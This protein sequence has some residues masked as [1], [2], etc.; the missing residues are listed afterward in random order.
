MSPKHMSNPSSP[1]NTVD[2]ITWQKINGLN[3]TLRVTSSN[4]VSQPQLFLPV[5]QRV[6]GT[7]AAVPQS[8][9]LGGLLLEC[10]A[11]LHQ[12]LQL[13]LGGH[14]TDTGSLKYVIQEIPLLGT[15]VQYN[16]LYCM[17]LIE[18]EIIFNGVVVSDCISCVNLCPPPLKS[19]WAGSSTRHVKPSYL[20]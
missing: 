3:S 19:S 8:L 12:S 4:L 6:D 20:R 14:T 16:I 7:R 13:V 9:H 18:L 15:L 1:D 11:G 2:F 5:F 10:L 17:L